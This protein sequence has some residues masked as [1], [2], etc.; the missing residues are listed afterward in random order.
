VI[1]LESTG[2]RY[3][4]PYGAAEDPM[5][6]L[7]KLCRHAILFENAY[8]TYPETIRSFFAVQ[9][10]TWP[11]LDTQPEDYEK[12]SAPGLATVLAGQGYRTGLFHSG[13]FGYLGMESV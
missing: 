7:S 3:L 6:H 13:R 4:R 8:T 5:P 10:S 2:A 11:A 1:H 9:C 12:V